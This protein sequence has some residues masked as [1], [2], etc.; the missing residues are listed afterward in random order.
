M[1]SILIVEDEEALLSLMKELLISHG[2]SV[3][4]AETI[5]SAG[6]ILRAHHVDLVISDVC[7]PDG[8][9]FDLKEKQCAL[10]P[11]I[12]ISGKDDPFIA[13]KSAPDTT[14]LMKPFNLDLLLMRVRDLIEESGER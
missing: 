8:N 2:Y 13:Y 4:T 10:S 7:L 14:F 6:N 1:K 12:F 9:G 11:F 5:S 3:L